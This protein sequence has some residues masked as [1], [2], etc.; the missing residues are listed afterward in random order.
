MLSTVGILGYLF[1]DNSSSNI[2]YENYKTQKV[3]KSKKHNTYNTYNHRVE[4]NDNDYKPIPFSK[5]R[6]NVPDFSQNL[7]DNYI[8]DPTYYK[9]KHEISNFFDSNE[10]DIKMKDANLLL[11]RQGY[12]NIFN[13]ERKYQ[14]VPLSEPIQV[15][16]GIKSD[17]ISTGGFHQF[18]RKMPRVEELGISQRGDKGRVN[19]GVDKVKKGTLKQIVQVDNNKTRFVENFPLEKSKSI[20]SGPQIR[21]ET[22]LDCTNRGD[23]NEFQI[24]SVTGVSNKG[25]Y[26][27]SNQ[28]L[29]STNRSLQNCNIS[30]NPHVSSGSYFNTK[31]MVPKTERENQL[32][33]NVTGVHQSNKGHENRLSDRV[34]TTLREL[35]ACTKDVGGG[36]KSLVDG[37]I[38]PT[39]H[40]IYSKTEHRCYAP[41]PGRMNKVLD[42]L[43][44]I[45]LTTE[46]DDNNCLREGNIFGK[47]VNNFT[48]RPENIKESIK[49]TNQRPLDLDTA[50][51][52]LKSNPLA[53]SIN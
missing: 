40:D 39:K 48:K 18:Y 25:S 31:Q 38:A 14:N 42:A 7:L 43:T 30:G 24:T 17:D 1:K 52:Q 44:A 12:E 37:P 33:D 20:Y 4:E 9:S 10:T 28:N 29:E 34:K 36:V 22:I 51:D 2:K 16:P 5:R 46:K 8:G 26:T 27:T 35:T 11:D 23:N 21:S 47:N 50:I 41:G 53:I 13:N 3:H 32:C 15:G 19:H 6:I 45:N 49:I